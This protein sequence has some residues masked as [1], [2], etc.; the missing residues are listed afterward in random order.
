MEQEIKFCTTPDNVSIAYA[1]VGSGP[2]FVKVANWM[3]HLE[4]DWQSPVWRHLLDEFARDHQFLR[5]DE[6]GTGLSDRKVEDLS[7]DAFVSDLE[8]VLDTVGL[9]KFPLFGISQG[10]PVAVAYAH[11]HPE[12]VTHLVLL[13]TFAT[14]W[15]KV[16]DL[17]PAAVERRKAEIALIK[18]G[19]G[20]DNPAFRQF[21]TTLCIP[22]GNAEEIES[23]NELQRNSA[24][25]ETASRIF[26]AIG[27][28]DV[29]HLLPQLDLPVL[30]L[31]SRNDATVNFEEGRRLASM[32]PGA[33][34]V[35][36]ESND[37]LLLKHEP[38][39]GR[40]VLEVRRFLGCEIETT[41]R[42]TEVL[43][44]K[45]CPTCSRTYSDANVNYCL[46][47]GTRLSSAYTGT[48]SDGSNPTK[49]MP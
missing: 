35:P 31:H 10:G 13:G 41:E 17:S 21:W 47:D 3:N 25:P 18:H 38:A 22:D 14:G 16:P 44:T 34:F 23:F 49:I 9:D 7:L 36:L 15:K 4:Q 8:A 40:F 2:P 24:S 19:W 45:T 33:K 30:S 12:R 1:S 28:F 26:E 6:R 48:V 39:W 42:P 37:H 5:Y 43:Q 20:N 11:R 27:D 46:D 29:S 32:V